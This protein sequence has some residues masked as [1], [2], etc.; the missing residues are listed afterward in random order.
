MIQIKIYAEIAV[1]I[2]FF[3]TSIFSKDP[4]RSEL[5]VAFSIIIGVLI[6]KRLSNQKNIQ[7]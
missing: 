4:I 6:Y 1:L 5:I 7:K 3:G 2:I